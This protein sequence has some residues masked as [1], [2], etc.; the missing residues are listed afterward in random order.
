MQEGGFKPKSRCFDTDGVVSKINQLSQAMRESGF[1]VIFI[2][3][4][5]SKENA[6]I[7]GTADWELLRSLKREVGDL[8]VGKTANDPFY[9]SE[10]QTTLT[11]LK[12]KELIITG[13]ATDFCVDAAIRAALSR[14]FNV[15]V[16]KDGHTC[17]DR[18]HLK[19]EQV[20]EHH[21]W[22]WEHM[23]STKGTVKVLAFEHVLKELRNQV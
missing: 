22:L 5:G 8:I 19:A 7:P 15:A 6:F 11:E 16:V 21:N 1:R 2:Q 3:H 9:A 17:G 10:L 23:I 13:W 20:I 12:V 14:D 4:D 18:P